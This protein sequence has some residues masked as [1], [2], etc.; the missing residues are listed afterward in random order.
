M[1]SHRWLN[2]AGVFLL[3]LATSCSKKA[4]ED[5]ATSSSTVPVPQSD[6]YFKTQFSDETQFIVEA[7]VTDLTEQVY[8]AKNHQLPDASS[9]SVHAVEKGDS[10][11]DQPSYDLVITLKSGHPLQVP[12]KVEGAIWSPEV[13]KDVVT[14]LAKEIGLEAGIRGKGIAQLAD[15]LTDGTA[16]TIESQN[17][18]VSSA[19]GSNF[20]DPALHEDAA[21][22]L[23]AFTLREH[24]GKFFEIRS[25]LCRITAH[26]AMAQF[27][28]NGQPMGTDGQLADAMLTGLMNNETDALKKLDAIKSSDP[29]VQKW[30]RA[31]RAFNTGDYRPLAGLN[32]LAGIERLAWF[33]AY[34]RSVHWNGAW[35]KLTEDEKRIADFPRMVNEGSYSVQTGH[36]L[37]EYSIP[38]EWREVAMIYSISQGAK[39]SKAN[40]VAALNQTPERCFATDSKTAVRVIGWGQ[41]AMFF[42]RHLGLALT[43]NYYF[44]HDAWGVPDEAKEFSENCDRDFDGLRFYPFI[45]RFNCADVNSF[46]RAVEDGLALTVQTPHLIPAE[47]W[48]YL[49]WGTSFSDRYLPNPNPHVNEWHKHNPPPG[50]A[51]DMKARLYHPSLTGRADAAARIDHLQERAPYDDVIAYYIVHDED[52]DKPTYEQAQKLYGVRLDYTP[53][54]SLMVA[55]TVD[56]DPAQFERLMSNAAAIYPR[57][58]FTLATYFDRHHLMDKAM[59]YYEKGYALD[60][61]RVSTSFYAGKLINYYLGKGETNEAESVADE[62]GEVYSYVG[63]QAK[64]DFLEAIGRYDEAFEWYA[65]IEERYQDS[66]PV[67]AF[68]LRY[69]SKTNDPKFDAELEK[70]K[71]ALFPQGIEKVTLKDFQSAPVDGVLVAEENNLVRQAGMKQGDVIVAINGTRVHNFQQYAAAREWDA[72]PMLSLIVWHGGKFISVVAAPPGHKFGVAFTDFPQK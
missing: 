13:Y 12:F 69:R 72:E 1:K 16:V 61:D 67:I 11:F 56:N 23:A 32:N 68:C 5:A 38:D 8:Y 70:R 54:A 47:C 37:L 9:F 21:L 2:W 41:W 43:Q 10:D 6:G 60:T 20:D 34:G 35:D 53:D 65:K 55:R 17:R 14:T 57:Y 30:V 42:Q 15:A 50:T 58:N 29:A 59:G 45:R 39:L 26:L 22:V 40:V 46:H 62:A 66:A 4:E 7:I 28:G 64:A 19:L 51:Y 36:E 63:L 27:L 71:S 18:V 33:H 3:F 25:P 24:S 49:C 44:L 31:L 48:N 52:H